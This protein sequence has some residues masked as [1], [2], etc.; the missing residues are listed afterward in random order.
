M[1]GDL[2]Q[3]HIQVFV[4]YF[5]PQKAFSPSSEY[6]KG[7]CVN[8]DLTADG[9]GKTRKKQLDARKKLIKWI[10]IHFGE[11]EGGGYMPDHAVS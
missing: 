3:I 6:Y 1:R 5:P 11:R 2:T 8:I 7:D 9:V 4:K 10:S